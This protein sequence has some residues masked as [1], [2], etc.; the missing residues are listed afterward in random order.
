MSGVD[1]MTDSSGDD[2]PRYVLGQEFSRIPEAYNAN[3]DH[4]VKVSLDDLKHGDDFQPFLVRVKKNS[5]FVGVV[6]ELYMHNKN[7][8]EHAYMIIGPDRVVEVKHADILSIECDLLPPEGFRFKKK[9][10]G[11]ARKLRYFSIT[12]IMEEYWEAKSDGQ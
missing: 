1:Y 5:F 4:G 11:K 7:T 12:K 10:R 2:F 9:A 3:P 6:G 8:L